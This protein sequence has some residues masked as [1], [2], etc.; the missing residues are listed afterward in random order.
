MFLVF[1]YHK[2]IVYFYFQTRKRV[3]QVSG[4]LSK[5]IRN[6]E[7]VVIYHSLRLKC[8]LLA[9]I[10]KCVYTKPDYEPPT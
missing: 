8:L 7:L 1:A 9:S 6:F 5:L 3:L 10:W 2:L 4:F